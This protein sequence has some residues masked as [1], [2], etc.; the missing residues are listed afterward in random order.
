MQRLQVIGFVVIKCRF[1]CL[2]FLAK[3][4]IER[5]KRTNAKRGGDCEWRRHPKVATSQAVVII[6]LNRM[7]YI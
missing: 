3:R 1:V 4:L 2:Y 5:L 6:Y 7:V